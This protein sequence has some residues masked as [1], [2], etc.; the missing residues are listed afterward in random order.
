ML[1]QLSITNFGYRRRY[2]DST[3]LMSVSSISFCSL[4][5]N[6]SWSLGGACFVMRGS[7]EGLLGS[8]DDLQSN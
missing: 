3:S 2:Y 6:V 7:S 4:L 1:S 8:S 5:T